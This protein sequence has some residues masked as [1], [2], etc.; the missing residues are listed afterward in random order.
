MHLPNVRLL[1][2]TVLSSR[3]EEMIQKRTLALNQESKAGDL[4]N[5]IHVYPTYAMANVQV[6]RQLRISALLSGASGRMIKKL[7]RFMRQL[8]HCYRVYRRAGGIVQPQRS[9]GHHELPAV[10]LPAGFR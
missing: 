1:G 10:P 4:A 3:A 8:K 2:A 5:S 9:D 6:S 7:A